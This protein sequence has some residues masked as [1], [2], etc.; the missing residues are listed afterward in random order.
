LHPAT[1][2]Q[3]APHQH[4]LRC[5]ESAYH[6]ATHCLQEG[7]DAAYQR[8]DIGKAVDL[9]SE[10]IYKQPN[11]PMWSERRAKVLIEGRN[12]SAAIMDYNEALRQTP[13]ARALTPAC[14]PSATSCSASCQGYSMVPYF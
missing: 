2:G 4:A 6:L 12:F 10:M 9:L 8:G 5:H 1:P 13:G 3:H 11:N 14:F 7:A